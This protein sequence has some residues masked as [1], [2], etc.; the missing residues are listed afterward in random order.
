MRRQAARGRGVSA[1]PL[2]R[3]AIRRMH[4]SSTPI[5]PP[6]DPARLERPAC[7]ILPDL[8]DDVPEG[9]VVRSAASRPARGAPVPCPHPFRLGRVAGAGVGAWQV[10]EGSFVL[11]WACNTSHASWDLQGAPACELADGMVHLLALRRGQASKA[12]MVSMMMAMETGGHTEFPEVDI[13]PTRAFRLDPGT[14]AK[15]RQS[16][17][18]VDGE[19]RRPLGGG[20]GLGGRR[21][22]H[23]RRCSGAGGVFPV[24]VRSPPRSRPRPL[25]PRRRRRALAPR[26]GRQR[27]VSD[28]WSRRGAHHPPPLREVAAHP[29]ALRRCGS[30]PWPRGAA[31]WNRGMEPL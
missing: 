21:A 4:T 14:T 31:G 23:P 8:G 9:W 3:A 6:A 18:V 13:V 24:A 2:C 10:E 7:T 19:V 20:W 11:L 29:R 26:E 28:R 17:L 12:R 25:P 5:R 15:G 22:P 1:L 30:T 16:M 27:R